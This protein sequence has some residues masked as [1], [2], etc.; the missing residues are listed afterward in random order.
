M[1]NCLLYITWVGQAC[2]VI[3]FRCW[4]T[5][6]LFLSGFGFSCAT[7][8]FKLS[9][10]W[11]AS[12]RMLCH[13][14]KYWLHA[15][16]SSSDW[17]KN[18]VHWIVGAQARRC[19]GASSERPRVAIASTARAPSADVAA[20]ARRCFLRTATRRDRFQRARRAGAWIF[21]RPKKSF[22][23]RLYKSS[24][25]SVNTYCI[26]VFSPAKILASSF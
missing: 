24:F 7:S 2:F 14:R 5:K 23:F 10:L 19:F 16:V 6:I 12:I 4:S 25:T 1:L 15:H 8:L 17:L 13:H 26:F 11:S 21:R 18:K 3:R 22:A 9:G 20:H